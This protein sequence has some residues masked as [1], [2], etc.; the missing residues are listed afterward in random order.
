MTRKRKPA[1]IFPKEIATCK[2]LDVIRSLKIW[3]KESKYIKLFHAHPSKCLEQ[4]AWKMNW[5]DRHSKKFRKRNPTELNHSIDYN[6]FQIIRASAGVFLKKNSTGL[7]NRKSL[8][9]RQSI[10]KTG[11]EASQLTSALVQVWECQF[12]EN[13]FLAWAMPSTSK[14]YVKCFS[15]FFKFLNFDCKRS[16]ELIHPGKT[17]SNIRTGHCTYLLLGEVFITS[18]AIL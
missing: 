1:V 16:M 18:D 11:K 8:G 15:I 17:C 14:E 7:P 6:I 3:P 12:L 10:G 9:P 5:N 4:P 13:V 2:F